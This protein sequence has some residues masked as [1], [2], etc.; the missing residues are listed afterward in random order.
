MDSLRSIFCLDAL[1]RGISASGRV[2][3]AL[4]LA[5]SLSSCVVRTKDWRRIPVAQHLVE[6][7]SSD[8]LVVGEHVRVRTRENKIHTFVVRRLESDAFYG[9]ARNNKEY[10]VPYATLDAME[11]IRWGWEVSGWPRGP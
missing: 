1:V 5:V 9:M 8:R 3:T 4:A 11:A 2:L 10:R 6:P 7:G